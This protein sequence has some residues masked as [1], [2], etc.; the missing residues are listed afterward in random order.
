MEN[1][2]ELLNQARQA[3]TSPG[4][5]LM[6]N[7]EGTI[8]YVGKAKNLKNRVTTYFQRSSTHEENPRIQIL[9]S[10]IAT[11]DL[12]LTKT[13]TE[14]LILE[15]SLIKKHKPKFNIRLR[16]DKN[17]PYLKI[18]NN[19]AYP[20]IE[21]TRKVGSSQNETTRYF[22]PFPSAWAAR[23]TLQLLN[24]SFQLR[25]CSDNAFRFRSRPCILYQMQKCSAPC[26]GHITAEEYQ[27]S[28][29]KI[30]LI[31]EG[32]EEGFIQNL[33]TRMQEASDH[34]DYES[35][36]VYRNQIKN[37]ELVTQTQSMVE[38]GSQ[39]DREIF[40][41]ARKQNNAHGTLLKIRSGKL[42]SVHHSILCNT[43]ESMSNA[44]VLSEFI[45]QYCH[46][47]K[48]K[49]T[50]SEI[51]LSEA[52]EDQS[53]LEQSFGIHITTLN[54]E[55][56]VLDQQLLN[57][58]RVN[59]QYALEQNPTSHLNSI[60]LDG[61][62]VKT[63]QE[64]QK[65]LHLQKIPFRIECYDISNIQN[66]DPVA[67]RAVF[68][69]GAP[70]KSLYRKYK[71]RTVIGQ[72]DFAMIREVLQRRFSRTAEAL[73]DL[74][75]IDGGMGQLSQAK[76]I[77]EELSLQGVDL[78]S[79]AKARTKSDFQAQEIEISS[80]RVFIPNRKNP[81]VLYRHSGIF[82]LLTHIRNEAHRFAIQYHR[83]LRSKH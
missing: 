27:K 82:R 9:V 11:F 19:Q 5:Y 79:L 77:F 51:L 15:A 10:Q 18:E 13:E 71:I 63:L 67:S 41:I 62:S 24:E 17:Y 1:Q 26:V 48:E 20:K 35:A 56:T 78:A 45:A 14:A 29:Q 7:L 36:A 47:Q 55:S 25:D 32:K 37:L 2:E 73:P 68:I 33:K 16:D 31:L 54:S 64:T 70:E 59:A 40:E 50:S 46:S 76:A 65:K 4:V 22:G 38:A 66:S 74:V 57:V 83:Q 61:H 3:T 75:L 53:W 8:L 23:E 44:Q 49:E 69:N 28:I 52:P 21:W 30:I 39:K 12:I 81:I 6:K 80:E 72:N 34:Q 60:A 42:I 43:D 58:A